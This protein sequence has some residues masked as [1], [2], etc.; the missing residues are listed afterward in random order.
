MIYLKDVEDV[1]SDPT[2]LA[3]LQASYTQVATPVLA[4][5]NTPITSIAN[6]ITYDWLFCPSNANGSSKTIVCNDNFWSASGL[7]LL[8]LGGG[9]WSGTSD[10]IFCWASDGVVGS[11]RVPCGGLAVC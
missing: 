4:G 10:G 2:S 1:T 9:A 8:A 5:S 3:D 7:R 11:S 6:D